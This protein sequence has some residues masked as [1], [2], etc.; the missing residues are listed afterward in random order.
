[1]FCIACG[2]PLVGPQP[3]FC[4]AC[5][6]P[7]P[8]PESTA[9][10]PRG[11]GNPAEDTAH[12][13]ATVATSADA[14]APAPAADGGTDLDGTL[15][16]PG[17]YDD[18]FNPQVSR[19]WTGTDW[20]TATQ[21]DPV[22]IARLRSGTVPPPRTPMAP[23]PEVPIAVPTPPSF[24][25]PGLYPDPLNPRGLRYWSGTR[26]EDR[27]NDPPGVADRLTH[28]AFPA[29]EQAP[30]FLPDAPPSTS[31]G[32]YPDPMDRSRRRYWTGTHWGERVPQASTRPADGPS[33]V[34]PVAATTAAGTSGPLL[35]GWIPWTYTAVI[36]LSLAV[37]LLALVAGSG[38]GR[39]DLNGLGN[40]LIIPSLIFYLVFGIWDA[41][42]VK[43]AAGGGGLTAAAVLL[44]PLYLF[45]RQRRLKKSVA[46]AVVFLATIL[47]NVVVVLASGT[48]LTNAMTGRLTCSD[49]VSE[50]IRISEENAGALQPKLV[51]VSNVRLVSDKQGKQTSG[52]H[53]TL[54]VC[55]GNG[56]YSDTQTAPT[57]MEY[58]TDSSGD[59]FV[60]YRT[61]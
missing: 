54:L 18:P 24:A 21:D 9:A 1:M 11:N 8:R 27:F 12:P 29:P 5:G 37:S 46:P 2:K 26:W 4:S 34:P 49:L 3:K 30:E 48:S 51:S 13:A 19:L 36:G 17:Y 56:Y 61:Q 42:R 47:L 10:A 50:S 53:N 28:G 35:A 52:S 16:P 33:N 32:Y 45:L 23:P 43:K 31:A 14:P 41:Q 40:V 58:W 55:T 59:A 39:A 22:R 15:P 60:E 7:V 25:V 38:K 20:D 57:R 44:P 6:A